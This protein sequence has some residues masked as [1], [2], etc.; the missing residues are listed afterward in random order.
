MVCDNKMRV[1]L[2]RTVKL[3]R[4]AEPKPAAAD[5]DPDEDRPAEPQADIAVIELFEN[6]VVIN[7]K[8]D[9][10]DPRT[11]AQKQQLQGN[12]LIYDKATGKFRV[13]GAGQ[14]FLWDRGGDSSLAPQLGLPGSNAGN[15]PKPGGNNAP[16][17]RPSPPAPVAN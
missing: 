10:L 3:N 5:D 16:G 4:P 11:I 12:Y 6:V 15:K 17:G 8:R 14:T 2:D 9:P 13:P 7:A 1:F